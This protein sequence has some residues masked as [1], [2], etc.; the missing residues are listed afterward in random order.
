MKHSEEIQETH[1]KL[2]TRAS[3][4]SIATA[5][6]LLLLKIIIW[7]AS[8]SIAV[9]S[10]LTDSLMDVI[11]SVVNFLAIRYAMIPADHNHQYGHAKAEALA[12][13]G[14]ALIIGSSALGVFLFSIE[15][16]QNPVPITAIGLSL[17]V[18]V[19]STLASIVLL[20][21]QRWV[22]FKT[23]SLAIQADSEHYKSD[24]F[25][26]AAVI[27]ALYGAA[28]GWGWLDPIVSLIVVFILLISSIGIFKEVFKVLMDEALAPEDEKSIEKIIIH[29]EQVKGLRKIQTRRAGTQI[30]IQIQLE[31]DANMNLKQ[32]KSVCDCV[33][34]RIKQAY[35]NAEINIQQE[36]VG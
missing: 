34:Y 4:L 6:F 14:Q 36:P 19:F 30:F 33:K 15:R 24:I 18:M 25:I 31:L 5:V 2:I 13:L 3:S 17:G 20:S 10:S 16:L 12:A 8:D 32:A 23:K 35:P 22:Y 28:K 26:N 29:C 21:Y 27:F 9:L 11:A 1:K 7:L